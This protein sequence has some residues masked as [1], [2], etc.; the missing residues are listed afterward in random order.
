MA[1][2]DHR[3]ARDV[4]GNDVHAVGLFRPQVD[5]DGRPYA[6][7]EHQR[8]IHHLGRRAAIWALGAGA[9]AGICVA[10]VVVVVL[11]LVAH[12]PG[13]VVLAAALS[14]GAF[15]AALGGLWGAFSRLGSGDDWR[16]AVT[17]HDPAPRVTDAASGRRTS[18][19]R[20]AKRLEDRGAAE[21][22]VDDD[23]SRRTPSPHPWSMN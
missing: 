12:P 2:T 6:A 5:D 14:A 13:S 20:Q 4:D 19:P 18:E 22:H 11:T 23:R 16:E 15:A 3:H 7:D 17:R 10:L 1:T 8:D 21:I 9:N